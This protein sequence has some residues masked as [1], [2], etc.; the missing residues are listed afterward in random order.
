MRPPRRRAWDRV[1]GGV[2]RPYA[3]ARP[4]EGADPLA[5]RVDRSR[6]VGE[7]PEGRAPLA[8]AKVLVTIGFTVMAATLAV[9]AMTKTTSG[10]GF[11]AAW[12]AWFGLG[13]GLAMPQTMNAALSAL[14]AEGSGSGSALISALRQVGATIGV[15]VLGTI[16]D[17]V[18]RAHLTVAGLPAVAATSARSSVVAGV[19]VAHKL[20]S[21]TLLDSA[22]G[23]F[24][25]GLDTMLWVCGG[26]A[27]VSAV[28]ALIFLPHRAE[29]VPAVS[30]A[31]GVLPAA[32]GESDSERA[33]L[34]V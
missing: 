15:A 32:T 12:F 30:T 28:L 23:A 9:G 24:V 33:Q 10:T 5:L 2:A 18:Y 13:L 16:L 14:S 29:G 31:D 3:P 27:L 7:A 22:R 19:Q 8:G 1:T 25:Q 17:S 11:A 4:S 21:A 6:L 26:I 20:G 34:E